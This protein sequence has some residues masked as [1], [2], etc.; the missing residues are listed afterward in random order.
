MFKNYF[1]ADNDERNI[2]TAKQF[3]EACG[4]GV[5]L[6]VGYHEVLYSDVEIPIVRVNSLVGY[7]NQTYYDLGIENDL[8]NTGMVYRLNELPDFTYAS[9]NNSTTYNEKEN[10]FCL[11]NALQEQGYYAMNTTGLFRRK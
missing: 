10:M 2:N 3:A 7:E 5:V 8:L 4:Q 9:S 6:S 1:I 11:R